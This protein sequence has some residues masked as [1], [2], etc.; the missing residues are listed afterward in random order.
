GSDVCSSDLGPD[1]VLHGERF[2]ATANYVWFTDG[3]PTA[4]GDPLVVGPFAS[5][6]GG[7]EIVVP[8]P[9]NAAP[10]DVLVRVPGS[11][12]SALSNAFPFDPTR[13]PCPPVEIYGVAKT[14]SLGVPAELFAQGRAVVG[15]DDLLIGTGNGIANANGIL[16]SGGHATAT[17]FF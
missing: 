3:S 7:T 12:G 17:P 13:E 6:A 14:T 1:V 9:A 4:H 16:F 10:G 8:L 11:T 5:S 15:I 2:D